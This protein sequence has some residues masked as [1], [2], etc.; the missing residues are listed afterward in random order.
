MDPEHANNFSPL[1]TVQYLSFS[2]M[3]I[4]HDWAL[5]KLDLLVSVTAN[6]VPEASFSNPDN[7]RSL[8]INDI[9]TT[10]PAERN[11]LAVTGLNGILH[12]IMSKIPIF[13]LLPHG[14]AFQELWT[15]KFAHGSIGN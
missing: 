2:D 1:G 12:G 3:N 8:F 11:V 4:G 13:A 15:I 7:K 14:K 6:A 9:V 5:I 10:G